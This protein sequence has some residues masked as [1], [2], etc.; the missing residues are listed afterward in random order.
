[1]HQNNGISHVL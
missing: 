1:M